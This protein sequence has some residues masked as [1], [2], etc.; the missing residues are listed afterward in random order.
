MSN[1]VYEVYICKYDG[2]IVYI[3]QGLKGRYKHCTSGTSHVYELNEIVFC[4]NKELLNVEIIFESCDQGKV[5]Q[6]EKELILK[7]RPIYNKDYIVGDKMKRLRD[8]RNVRKTLYAFHNP[9]KYSKDVDKYNN[10]IKELLN[11]H[12]ATDILNKDFK[13]Y[14]V[15]F[16]KGLGYDLLA[17]FSAAIRHTRVENLKESNPYRVL[18][19]CLLQE[20]EIDLYAHI[21]E[22]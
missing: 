7:H 14:S 12:A 15:V 17:K 13:L 5:K 9:P 3:G 1:K 4:K 21:A 2:E 16:Y 10:L 8:G 6:L 22:R 18:Y 11:H 19:N 20:F